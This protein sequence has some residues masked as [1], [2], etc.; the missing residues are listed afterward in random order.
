MRKINNKGF[1]LVEVL[2]VIAII[3]ILGL[4]AVPGVLNSIQNSKKSSYNIMISDIKIAG[5]TL[6]EEIEYNDTELYQY[7]DNGTKLDTKVK[8]EKISADE[9]NLSITQIKTNL[10]TLVSNG[11]LKGTQK[12]ENGKKIPILT[13]PID[14]K[15]IG[16][17]KVIIRKVSDNDT[18]E[19]TTYEI[20]GNTEDNS[21]PKT[22]EYQKYSKT[23]LMGTYKEELG[24]STLFSFFDKDEYSYYQKIKI[25]FSTDLVANFEVDTQINYEENKNEFFFGK[26]NSNTT[27]LFKK[28]DDKLTKYKINLTTSI[29]SY[30]REVIITKTG[31]LAKRPVYDIYGNVLFYNGSTFNKTG[32]HTSYTPKKEKIKCSSSS[33]YSTCISPVY[34]TNVDITKSGIIGTHNVKWTYDVTGLKP[35]IKKTSSGIFQL[36]TSKKVYSTNYEFNS[37]DGTFTLTN[38]QT[39]DWQ[40]G[41]QTITNDAK[42]TCF[43]QDTSCSVL[44]EVLPTSTTTTIDL[45]THVAQEK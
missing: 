40:S 1:T 26:D 32:T 2:A 35:R 23:L 6:F 8:T 20:I 33:K 29:I 14:D 31:N 7:S 39:L 24:K 15:D 28:D 45:Q 17:C 16:F 43:N 12:E 37:Y 9:E 38:P 5:E 44:Y 34:I 25:N 36:V 30:T 42:Y 10:Q 3:A 41:K 11:I 18:Q 13:N 4:I 21:C 19:K 27:Y 22:E